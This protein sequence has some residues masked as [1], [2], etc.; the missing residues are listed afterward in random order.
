MTDRVLLTVGTLALAVGL[1]A[2]MLKGWRSRQRRQ[3]DLPAPPPGPADPG[4]VLVGATPGLF[5]GTTYAEHWLDRVAVHGL[6]HRAAGWL[7][8]AGTGVLIEREGQDDLHLAYGDLV[9]AEPGDAL[10]GKFVGRDGMLLLTWR[11]GGHL[12]TS[13]F[14]ADDHSTHRRLAD[15]V[16]AAIPAHAPEDR[17]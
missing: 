11:L 10:A 16:T 15:A 7:T 9:S 12:L 13:G 2:L 6:G 1:Y 4:A 3:G 17:A 8:V 14:R 5:V